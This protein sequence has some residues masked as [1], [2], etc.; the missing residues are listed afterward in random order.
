M[1]T[2]RAKKRSNINLAFH[3][4]VALKCVLFA[5][6]VYCLYTAF[7]KLREVSHFPIKQVKVYGVHN[8]DREGI[9]YLLK[10]L[11]SQGFF[12]VDVDNVKEHIL[13]SPWVTKVFV[14]RVWPDK[15]LITLEEKVPLARWNRNQILSTSGELFAPDLKNFPKT[16][17]Q[18][19]GPDGEQIQMMEFYKKINSMFTPLHFKISRLELLPSMSWNI[20][21]D[22]G[23]KVSMGNKDV[24]THIRHFVKVYPK[25][26]G[27]RAAEVDYIDMRYSNG[28][29]VKWKITT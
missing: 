2:S 3:G 22:N 14:Q 17:P 28:L 25:I 20:T 11:V 12:S 19:V 1:T 15:V 6:L 18:F 16:F 5:V 8:A 4:K 9:Q 13:Q 21:F 23:I 29:A 24:L 10:P 27:D 26:V 7:N